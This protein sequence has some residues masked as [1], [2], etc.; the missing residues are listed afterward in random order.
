[1]KIINWHCIK[2]L[3][4]NYLLKELIRNFLQISSIIIIELPLLK[5]L[6]NDLRKR[7]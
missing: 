6:S 3:N 7:K 4:D 5:Y 2:I 1:M